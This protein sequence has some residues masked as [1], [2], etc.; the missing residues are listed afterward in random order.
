MERLF[1]YFYTLWCKPER[2]RP[3]TF[4]VMNF[5]KLKKSKSR[6]NRKSQRLKFEKVHVGASV[7]PAGTCCIYRCYIKLLIEGFL[8]LICLTKM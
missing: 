5:R 2:S 3:K 1:G 7:V 4:R 8:G 6:K